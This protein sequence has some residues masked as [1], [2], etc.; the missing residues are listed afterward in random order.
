MCFVVDLNCCV[1]RRSWN[2]GQRK[3]LQTEYQGLTAVVYM[4]ALQARANM[5]FILFQE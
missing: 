3:G 5:I 1:W 4:L 2:N